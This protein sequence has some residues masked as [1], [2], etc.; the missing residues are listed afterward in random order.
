MLILPAAC[1][2]DV[3][4]WHEDKAADQFD[5]RPDRNV[6][7]LENKMW[8]EKGLTRTIYDATNSEDNIHSTG[9]CSSFKTNY[10]HGSG[11]LWDDSGNMVRSFLWRDGQVL[12]LSFGGLLKFQLDSASCGRGKEK[13]SRRTKETCAVVTAQ[14]LCSETCGDCYLLN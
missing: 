7:I 10:N 4:T 8:E 14:K 13:N 9:H 1:M 3:I 11:R 2:C 12:S 5:L 6:L